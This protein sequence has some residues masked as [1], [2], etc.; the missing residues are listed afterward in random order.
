MNLVGKDETLMAT[1]EQ[2]TD[3]KMRLLIAG[4][5]WRPIAKGKG[6]QFEKG[7]GKGKE[8]GKKGKARPEGVTDTPTV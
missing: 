1:K 4:H 7:K 8:K 5:Q 6:E 2:A 3:Q